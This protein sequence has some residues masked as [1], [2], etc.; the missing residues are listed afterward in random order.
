VRNLGKEEELLSWDFEVLNGIFL[1]DLSKFGMVRLVSE[2]AFGFY[3]FCLISRR[4]PRV[5]V[6]LQY[7]VFLVEFIPLAYIDC[8]VLL[9]ARFRTFGDRFERQRHFGVEI[10]SV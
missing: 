1:S 7:S 3:D 5:R 9:V 4:G 10:C 2:W 8:I 6:Q